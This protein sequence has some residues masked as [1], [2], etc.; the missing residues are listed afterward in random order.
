MRVLPRPGPF[1]WA[2][3]NNYG[4]D[5]MHGEVA[6]LLNNDTDV[7]EPGWLRELVSQALRPEIGVA[8]AKL[9]YADGRV[10]HAGVVLGPAARAT[11][12]WRYAPGDARGY[13]GP[14]DRHAPGHRPDRR[15]PGDPPRRL[16]RGRAAAMPST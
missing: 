16:S 7:I 6:V 12:M 3:L 14:V 13:L 8:G 10:Q 1:N 4:F 5:H 11:H 15:L 9:L 2:A